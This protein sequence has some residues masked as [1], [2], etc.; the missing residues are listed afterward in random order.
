MIVAEREARAVEHST[1]I[2][3]QWWV[4]VKTLR[5]SMIFYAVTGIC[6]YRL[7]RISKNY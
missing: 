3:L 5:T 1:C 6:E 4:W 7:T 2:R